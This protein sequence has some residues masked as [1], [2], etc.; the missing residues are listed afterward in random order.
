MKT[1]RL[2]RLID[3]SAFRIGVDGSTKIGKNVSSK[4][5]FESVGRIVLYHEDICGDNFCSEE[6]CISWAS[7]AIEKKDYDFFDTVVINFSLK[8][9]P[10]MLAYY[11]NSERLGTLIERHTMNEWYLS[12]VE[13]VLYNKWYCIFYD[14][15]FLFRPDINTEQASI[16]AKRDASNVLSVFTPTTFSYSISVRNL[17]I[18][19]NRLRFYCLNSTDVYLSQNIKPVLTAFIAEAEQYCSQKLDDRMI[20]S[21]PMIEHDN[22]Y[23]GDVYS[24]TYLGSMKQLLDLQYKS[25]I[26]YKMCDLGT[27]CYSMPMLLLHDIKLEEDWLNDNSSI[28]DLHPQ[29]KMGRIFER[30]IVEDFAKKID[31]FSDSHASPE[32]CRQ[33][34]INMC[35]YLNATEN[36]YPEI[37]RFLKRYELLTKQIF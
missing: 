16:L 1:P 22:K 8:S 12:S 23:F 5:I 35:D 25:N 33:N 9:V 14:N 31:T 24:I 13:Q 17:S 27:P 28:D 19:L 21:A 2:S 18:L 15:A 29:S 32:I 4:E 36:T 10:K 20:V 37:Y 34:S 26:D 6:T 11:L 7:K 30:G 3:S